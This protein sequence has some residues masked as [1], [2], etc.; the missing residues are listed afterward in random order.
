M[1]ARKGS[2]GVEDGQR[3]VDLFLEWKNR[4]EDFKPYIRQGLLNQSSIARDVGFTRGVFATNAEIKD[5]HFP[6]L[7]AELEK[8]GILKQRAAA[9]AE[10]QPR[11]N[12]SN[13]LADARVKQIQEENE[14]VKA[15]NRELRARLA[16]LGKLKAIDEIVSTTGRLPW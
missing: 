9:P 2:N 11:H 7:I 16:K 13:H 15:E 6:A 5:V 10:N 12:M 8:Q 1:S 3:N 4:V 14:A